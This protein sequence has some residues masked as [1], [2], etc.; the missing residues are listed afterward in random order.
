MSTSVVSVAE[1][2]IRRQENAL[3]F[4]RWLKHPLQ[5]GTLA[6]ISSK[7]ANLA[8]SCVAD[9]GGL[10]VEIGAGT[11]RLSRALLKQGINPENLALVELDPFF[12]NF[13]TKTLP[14]VLKKDDPLPFVI[15]GD[16]TQLPNLLPANYIGQVDIVFSVI[17]LMYLPNAARKAIIEAA[18]Q[19]LKP[20]GIIIHV[21][22]SA[23]SPVGFM[24]DLE[25]NRFG[26]LW[27]NFP[28]G[29]VWHYQKKAPVL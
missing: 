16:A 14:S 20:G 5:M 29:F 18:F 27:V 6:P 10:Y 4:R 7:L 23:K 9:P 13:L 22:Y 21:T 1:K 17:P 12:C 24:T 25:Q 11:G 28:P 2:K 3:F 19:V 15:E 26:K 8:A